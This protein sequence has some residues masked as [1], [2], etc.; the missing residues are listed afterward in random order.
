MSLC[1]RILWAVNILRSFLIVLFRRWWAQERRIL[2]FKTWTRKPLIKSK[3][4]FLIESKDA[5]GTSQ[6]MLQ[7]FSNSKLLIDS[8]NQDP[9]KWRRASNCAKLLSKID[10]LLFSLLFS[11]IY[12][13]YIQLLPQVLLFLCM[14]F[15]ASKSLF[16]FC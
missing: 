6:S 8:W 14:R 12:S 9:N 16:A 1:K 15:A 7:Y 3:N 13:L 2:N 11:Y 5:S 4:Y 10:V